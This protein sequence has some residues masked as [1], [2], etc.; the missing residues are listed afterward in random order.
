MATYGVY[1]TRCP[2]LQLSPYENKIGGYPDFFTGNLLSSAPSCA[3]CHAPLILVVQVYCPLEASHYH[4]LLH[5]FC[6][7]EPKCWGNSRSWRVLR[8]QSVDPPCARQERKE[9]AA[10]HWQG[11]ALADWCGGAEEWGECGDADDSE[12]GGRNDTF[13]VISD[14][15]VTSDLPVTSEV[16]T[17]CGE[18]TTPACATAPP[19][20]HG[21]YYHSAF[22]RAMGAQTHSMETNL[23]AKYQA[24]Y[25][26]SSVSTRCESGRGKGGGRV[27]EK[28]RSGG[29][30]EKYE[31]SQARHGD[32]HFLKFQKEL[33]NSPQQ[34][35]RYHWKG[36]AIPM[37]AKQPFETLDCCKSCGAPRVFECQLMPALVYIIQTHLMHSPDTPNALP[38]NNRAEPSNGPALP[39]NGTTS[40][41]NCPR[42][43]AVEFGTAIVYSCPDS[44]WEHLQENFMEELVIVQSESEESEFS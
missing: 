29:G 8:S 25:P 11:A 42:P 16:P 40:T 33:A 3:C 22:V 27:Q 12:G 41:N 34:I 13:P 9:P 44:C 18:V 31:K 1:D 4:R 28:T 19:C 7:T 2:S 14:L 5:I 32:G 20:Y 43:A 15:D 21:P 35:L 24:E 10:S 23:L 39:N 17:S 30:S 36:T 6:C 37:T 26:D 38:N